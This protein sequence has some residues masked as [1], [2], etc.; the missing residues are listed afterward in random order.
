MSALFF[1][2]SSQLPDGETVLALLQ[3]AASDP[4]HRLEFSKQFEAFNGS[5]LVHLLAEHC[6]LEELRWMCSNVTEVRFAEQVDYDGCSPLH[7]CCSSI[8]QRHSQGVGAAAIVEMVKYMAE[9]MGVNVNLQDLSGGTAAHCAAESALTGGDALL[10][11][12][13][14]KALG[15]DLSLVTKSHGLDVA[16]T[17]A[18]MHGPGPWLTWCLS[19]GG[20]D[21]SRRCADGL[22]AEDYA[23]EYLEESG[24]SSDESEGSGSE[25]TSDSESEGMA[26]D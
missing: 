17:V 23:A 10:I 15:A 19:E 2:Y 16:M 11:L 14:L 4:A 25:F 7:H 5:C 3:R 1:V 21:G 8:A 22:S 26:D 13:A 12:Q 24:G 18:Q 20:C 6:R 9:D